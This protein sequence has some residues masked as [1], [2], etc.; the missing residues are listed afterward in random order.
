MYFLAVQVSTG[1]SDI[2]IHHT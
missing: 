1:S 2:G